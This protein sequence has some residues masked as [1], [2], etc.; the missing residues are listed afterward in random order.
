[1]TTTPPA[2][3]LRYATAEL[4]ADIVQ[5]L[6]PQLLRDLWRKR[7]CGLASN[8]SDDRRDHRE[9]AHAASLIGQ[10]YHDRFLVE[11]IQNANDQALRGGLR[12]STVVVA[13]TRELLA[14]SNSGQVVTASNLERVSSL[15]DSDKTGE[16]T[17]NKGVGFKAVYQIT[18]TPEIYS[19]RQADPG[20][21]QRS[22][23]DEFGLGLALARSPFTNEMLVADVE[24]SIRSYLAENTGVARAF[25][26]RGIIDPLAAVRAE[27]SHVAGFK[28]PLPRDRACMEQRM[29]ALSISTDL[30]RDIRTLVVLPLRDGRADQDVG[31][32]IDMLVH[33]GANNAGLAE[34]AMLFLAGIGRLVVIDSV[35]GE[36]W[37]I[38]CSIKGSPGSVQTAE[39]TV[40]S[41]GG[42]SC[43]NKYWLLQRDALD[44][45]HALAAERG[46]ILNKALSD[47]G[48]EAWK[49]SD[50]IPV[51]VALPR[52]STVELSPLEPDGRFCLGLPTK[53]GT[54]LPVHVDARFF[55]TISRTG[56]DFGLPY[57][58]MLLDVA[59]A[60]L[61]ELIEELKRSVDLEDRR[62][63]T[64]ALHRAHGELAERVYAPDALADEAI[65]L[66][67]DGITYARRSECWL[68][69]FNE[70]VLLPLVQKSL[71]ARPELLARLPEQGLLICCQAMLES[72]SLPK[73][74]GDVHPWLVGT[75]EDAS[76]VEQAAKD[77]RMNGLDFWEPFVGALLDCFDPEML[78]GLTWLPIGIR[79]LAAPDNGIYFPAPSYSDDD[80]EEVA[81]VPDNVAAML[82]LL[83]GKSMRLREDGRSLTAL[84]LR[85]D[86]KKL[87]LRPRKIKLL[88]DALFPALGR[89]V[90][91][92]GSE[93]HDNESD[94]FNLLSQ[95]VVWIASLKPL[96]RKKLDCS[97][98]L[99]PVQSCDGIRWE[100]PNRIYFGEGWGLPA[101]IE[102]M[103]YRAYPE[104]RLVPFTIIRERAGANADPAIWRAAAE[105][106][107]VSAIP[108]RLAWPKRAAPL[109]S[110]N[111]QLR[112]RG[113]PSPPMPAVDQIYQAYLEYL[114][115]RE[116]HW[117]VPFAHD[118]D[119]LDW[120]DGLEDPSRR[121]HVVDLMLAAPECRTWPTDVPLRRFDEKHEECTVPRMWVFALSSLGWPVFVGERGAGNEIFR[122]AAN[123][124]WHVP[125]TTR[126][127]A[128]A[129]L[130][131]TVP[132]RL[133]PAGTL[134]R[135]L[136]I[137]TL[138]DASLERLF[139]GLSDLACRL[140]T[141]LLH[142]GPEAFSLAKEL[143]LRIDERL[144]REAMKTV[145][146]S[147]HLPFLRGHRL[148]S[149]NLSSTSER[150]VF[151]DDP[152][153]G[154]HVT[155]IG[156]CYRVPLPRDLPA[157]R[158]FGLFLRTW[159][160]KR[161][162]RTS[163]APVQIGFTPIQPTEDPRFLEWLRSRYPH[164]EVALELATLLTFSGE[165]SV[166][167]DRLSSN[168][169]AFRELEL[170]FGSFLEPSVMSFYDRP[171]G[172][173]LVSVNLPQ[174]QVVAAT[175]ELGGARSRDLIAGYAHSLEENATAAFLRERDIGEVELAETNDLAGLYRQMD[176]NNLAPALWAA[177]QHL[178]QGTTLDEAVKWWS[179]TRHD[180][181][182]IALELGRPEMANVLKDA[183]SFRSPEGEL[184][185]LRYLDVP[186]QLWQEGMRRRNGSYYVFSASAKRY[187]TLRDYLVAIA[188]ELAVRDT[189][190]ALSALCPALAG[191]AIAEL[192]ERIV[193]LPPD[194][195]DIDAAALD[196]V[197]T[198]IVEFNGLVLAFRSLPRSPWISEP[199]LPKGATRRGVRLFLEF[200]DSVRAI[201][202]RTAVDAVID[203]AILLARTFGEVVDRE[204]LRTAPALIERT[205][206]AW[207]HVYGALAM[208]R[209]LLAAA[210]IT[211][212]KLSEV[213][214]FRDPSTRPALMA[215]L[216]ELP[217]PEITLSEPRQAVLGEAMTKSELRFDFSSGSGGILGKKLAEAARSGVDPASLA[218][219]RGP[220]K[221]T[222]KGDGGGRGGNVSIRNPAKEP[223]LTGDIGEAYVHEWLMAILGSEYGAECWLSKARTRYGFPDSGS[224]GHGFDFRVPNTR[225]CIVDHPATVLLMEVK[226]TSGDGGGAFPMSAAEWEKAR[227]CHDDQ[228]GPLYVI[229]RVCDV[230]AAPR[231]ADIVVDPYGAFQRGEVRLANRDLWVTVAPLVRD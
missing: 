53:Q 104:Q 147:V 161:V 59:V 137:P 115:T 92:G 206:G 176:L 216:P 167:S 82:H 21:E 74:D 215:K 26:E 168:W 128:F 201:E 207:A 38:S 226:S 57:N 129:Q 203:V 49:P 118:V 46:G 153:R 225:G 217:K 221:K 192:P 190:V 52:P 146:S 47:F 109:E 106:M 75:G 40:E 152:Q 211:V 94:A 10:D 154:R 189:D 91:G 157:D 138:A 170:V 12:G 131:N 67:W 122:L 222:G 22:L 127:S 124:L 148:H 1:M 231:I 166:R 99:V 70:C 90:T 125:Q 35:R 44:C 224:D 36:T 34:L 229:I 194:A 140:D 25:A 15:A 114:C 171:L 174:S 185:L 110:H 16:L 108:I 39:V 48:L 14:V 223:E 121:M 182:S 64:L 105:V 151:D 30:Q 86:D 155:G 208:L 111:R 71:V 89:L 50:P 158:T 199:P 17:G 173:L 3:T 60:L 79:D 33:A 219:T 7:A 209:D 85:L 6:A 196:T 43:T 228:G 159:G 29:E 103:L 19:A 180:A 177:K 212:R 130:L 101:E 136:G 31:Q 4:P 88:E 81:N 202:A 186:W 117:I 175:W 169:K 9:I 218:G 119:E 37:T 120:V 100:R 28:F 55:A 69:N 213:H 61:T 227:E 214:A 72:A 113:A 188:R 77:R 181:E 163:T 220:L 66:T 116:T 97:K 18:D 132:H 32:A 230:L 142:V 184:K 191:V 42:S 200:P 51:T 210:P 134:L 205:T 144:A 123:D 126:K 65:V 135:A 149:L 112:K 84:S 41:T 11:L 160:S 193:T 139:G 183:L 197:L 73:M 13:R 198:S 2:L 24:E 156:D 102:T 58:V 78:R 204:S 20:T 93:V 164:T 150:I 133:E 178:F 8:V 76:V 63:V 45:P 165:R 87:V 145:P 162:L 27:Y 95:A 56:L 179:Q 5:G 80:E 83:D 141:E 143:F 54:G 98:A 187:R 68:P 23:L 172:R 195:V 96:S 62:A 107:Q